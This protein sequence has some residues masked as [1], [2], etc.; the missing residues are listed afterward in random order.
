M[1]DYAWGSYEHR[2]D[3]QVFGEA[4][5]QLA[6]SGTV[7]PARVLDFAR[8]DDSP[9]HEGFEWDDA[10]AGESW[11]KQQARMYSNSIR[12]VMTEDSPPERVLYHVCTESAGDVYATKAQLLSDEEMRQ[13]ALRQCLTTLHAAREKYRELSE[14][15]PVWSAVDQ[16]DLMAV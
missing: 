4:V 16:L 11:R 12:V 2:L 6:A 9:I 15:D 1:A 3:P 14:L 10:A 5:E 7:T 13:S 8:P